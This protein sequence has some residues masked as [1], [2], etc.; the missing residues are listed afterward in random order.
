MPGLFDSLTMAARSLQA[1]QF[2]INVTGQNISNVNTTGYSR[3]VTDFADVPMPAGGGV[4]VDGVRSIRDSLIERRLLAQI[5][6]GTYDAAVADAL[7]IVET[8]LGRTGDTLDARLNEFFDAF[9]ELAESPT[10]A[11][12]RREVQVAGQALAAAFNDTAV[13][14]DASR[15]DADARLRN[16]VDEIN[17]IATRIA[18]INAAM[19]AATANNG[20]LTLR[21]EQA[22]LVRRLSE[23]ASVGT[24]AREDGG[25]DVTIGNGRALVVGANAYQVATVSTPPSGHASVMAGD[26]DIT[27]EVTGG[28]VGG[29]LYVRDSAIP[30]YLFSLDTLAAQTSASINGV[31]TAGYD[32][33]GAAGGSFFSYSTPPS[34]VSGAAAALR[35]DPA[36]VTDNNLIA[37]AGTP[38]AGDNATARALAALR[39]ERVLNGTAT[40]HDGWG[41]L[42]YT[43]GS[44]VQSASNA[45][46]T[47]QRITS[48]IDAL[49]DQVSGVSLDEEALNLLKFQRA[50]EANAKFFTTINSLLDTLMNS[51][52]P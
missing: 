35:V 46:D 36:I 6:L 9:A 19:P 26:F 20:G 38:L 52:R 30:G 40:L 50:Y 28:T 31:H 45:L 5:P 42:V 13:R 3:R 10:S 11:V 43:V 2:G 17:T 12:A 21:D 48:E 15:Q 4:E 32:L 47:H 1:Q 24:I 22:T 39:S 8:S 33:S 37:A 44:D 14:L 27:S 7:A 18:E 29:L 25:V 41:D 16:A 34:G 51:Y 49:R 23:L